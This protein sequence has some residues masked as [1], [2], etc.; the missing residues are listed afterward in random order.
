MVVGGGEWGWLWRRMSIRIYIGVSGRDN[1]GWGSA[2]GR[3]CGTGYS[4]GYGEL[5]WWWWFRVG[6]L[7]RAGC[8]RLRMLL[9][10]GT[11]WG[12]KSEHKE[13]KWGGGRLTWKAWWSRWLRE[14][15]AV[16]E[17]AVSGGRGG[18]GSRERWRRWLTWPLIAVDVAVNGGGGRAERKTNARQR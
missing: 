7:G 8:V 12:A 2:G 18:R 6:V 4:P 16:V 14:P 15:L 3:E 13:G 1:G 9:G 5:W 11:E 17:G 10:G